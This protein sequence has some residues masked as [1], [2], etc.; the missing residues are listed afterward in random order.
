MNDAVKSDSPKAGEDFAEACRREAGPAWDAACGHPFTLALGEG[1][2]PPAAMADY[3]VQ[4]YAFVGTLVSMV[5][6]AVGKAPDIAAQARLSTFLAAVT[7]AENTYF[8]RS[9]DALQVPEAQRSRPAL[10][11]VTER[12]IAAMEDAGDRGSYGEILAT[13]LPAEWIYLSWAEAQAA[14]SP[15]AFYFQ[16]WIDLHV[17]AD[18]RA[19]VLWLKDETDRAAAAAGAQERRAMAERFARMVRLEVDF[20]DM[21][22]TR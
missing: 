16:E 3:L 10:R 20:F 1:T 7:S 8:Q 17:N 6:F 2:L 12:L 11:E 18:F 9:F 15:G 5:G 14:K 22:H 21:F 13:L 19:F 4:D